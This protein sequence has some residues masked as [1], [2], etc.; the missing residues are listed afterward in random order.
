MSC[1]NELSCSCYLTESVVSEIAIV[2]S[3]L[4][5]VDRRFPH[6]RDDVGFAFYESRFTRDPS[7][8]Q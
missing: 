3:W 4:R 6:D 1:V 5:I 2:A 7:R 8:T